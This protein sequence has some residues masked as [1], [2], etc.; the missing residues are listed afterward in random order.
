MSLPNP[1]LSVW[2]LFSRLR[3]LFAHVSFRINWCRLPLRSSTISAQTTALVK[4]KTFQ[5]TTGW[6]TRHVTN[7]PPSVSCSILL[8][9][10]LAWSKNLDCSRSF[11][12]N[13]TNRWPFYFAPFGRWSNIYFCRR[14]PLVASPKSLCISHNRPDNFP[15]PNCRIW[16]WQLPLW[17]PPVH[18]WRPTLANCSLV[19]KQSHAHTH[20]R[21][22]KTREIQREKWW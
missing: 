1:S 2:N 19:P 22:H 16:S 18:F 13:R 15:R 6:T 3:R 10:V 7:L 14:R 20:T 5:S 11:E 21:V 8:W 9:F 4:K 17:Y 12:S